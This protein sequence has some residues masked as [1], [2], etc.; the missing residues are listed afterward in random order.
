MSDPRPHP[1]AHELRYDSDIDRDMQRDAMADELSNEPENEMS[2][3]TIKGWLYYKPPS[4]YSQKDEP[5]IYFLPFS[6]QHAT[7]DTWGIGVREHSIEVEISDDFD[8]RP[9]Q[10]AMLDKE[11][12]ETRA[13]FTAR[14]NELMNTRN[15]LLC[16][17]NA[18]S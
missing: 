18:Q 6:P 3:H 15:K 12:A 4:K 7:H 1:F 2:K 14:I 17:E 9:Q 16:I 8:P 5:T 10:I 11:I 13:K